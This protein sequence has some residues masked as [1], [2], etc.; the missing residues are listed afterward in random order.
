MTKF[1]AFGDSITEGKTTSSF[2]LHAMTL[3][4]CGTG[5][6]QFCQA[7]SY[8]FKL[9]ALLASRYTDQK[10]D[11][12]N[13]AS[14]G[15]QAANGLPRLDDALR[16]VMPEVL[17]LMDGANDLIA[18]GE[19]GIPQAV[20]AIRVLVR[21]AMAH[22][23]KVMLATLPP[24]VPNTQRGGAAPFLFKFNDSLKS[25]GVQEGAYIVDIYAGFDVSLQG[26]D[27][28]HP[29]DAGYTRIAEIFRD[30]IRETFETVSTKARTV[31][32][33]PSKRKWR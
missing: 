14:G 4:P 5:D 7:V 6:Q 31:T 18:F 25:M 22:G 12:W 29:S 1:L 30:R 23:A 8:P 21:D 16:E 2:N 27:G 19:P 26:P 10:I 17:L 15:E 33:E 28:L 3:G 11:V 9:Q 13:A 24:Q 20:E 32:G